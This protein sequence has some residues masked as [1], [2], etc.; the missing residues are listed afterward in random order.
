MR[1]RLAITPACG[2]NP[3]ARARWT[4]TRS[5]NWCGQ[6]TTTRARDNRMPRSGACGRQWTWRIRQIRIAPPSRGARAAP[7]QS[8]AR[9]YASLGTPRSALAM[10]EKA[11]A[12]I[13]DQAGP[14]FRASIEVD[15]ARIL[16]DF[17]F[18]G[19]PLPHL[20]QALEYHSVPAGATDG[21]SWQ[22]AR[23]NTDAHCRLRRGVA[24]PPGNGG[25]PGRAPSTRR[26]GRFPVPCD[27]H[28]GASPQRHPR[29]D[30]AHRGAGP[31]QRRISPT[32]KN[33]TA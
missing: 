19:D 24:H 5:A 16:R 26:V 3:A 28:R 11:K 21:R 7:T 22:K 30:L 20:L 12:L 18:L 15:T 27:R 10:L 17:P 13:D 23:R 14:T 31:A 6:L 8:T 25:D 1:T 2:R 33:P 4:M 29:R 32:G 9:V